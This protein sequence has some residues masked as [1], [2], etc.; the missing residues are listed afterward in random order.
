M[1]LIEL[2]PFRRRELLLTETYRDLGDRAG[3]DKWDSFHGINGA[4]RR[5]NLTTMIG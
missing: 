5:T 1:D 2:L 4:H 3:E